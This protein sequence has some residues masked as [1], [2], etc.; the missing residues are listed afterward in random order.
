MDPFLVNVIKFTECPDEFLR[1]KFKVNS[2]QI[3]SN[4]FSQV[5][6]TMGNILLPL[7]P[8]LGEK[9]YMIIS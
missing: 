9:R 1:V 5:T 4:S 2:P 7:P 6:L 3:Y 8:A